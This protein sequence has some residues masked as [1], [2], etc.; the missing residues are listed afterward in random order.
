MPQIR[1]AWQFQVIQPGLALIST[2][3]W[4]AEVLDAIIL[5][6]RGTILGVPIIRTIIFW[7]YIGGPL[8]LRK[9]WHVITVDEVQHALWIIS[10]VGAL[11]I[12]GLLGTPRT[13]FHENWSRV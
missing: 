11:N 7:V 6:I 10:S 5:K 12:V 4:Q 9:L 2:T 13:S 8:I 1:M 3:T